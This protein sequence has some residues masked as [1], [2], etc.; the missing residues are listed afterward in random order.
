MYVFSTSLAKKV[1]LVDKIKQSILFYVV[2][3]CLAQKKLL[4][5]TD[6]FYV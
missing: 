4:I 5:L 2:F 6:G 3:T 1:K